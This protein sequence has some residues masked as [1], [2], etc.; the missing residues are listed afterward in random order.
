MQII[1]NNIKSEEIILIYNY[2]FGLFIL[3][4]LKVILELRNEKFFL[5]IVY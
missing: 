3:E 4:G 2:S 5:V 1:R